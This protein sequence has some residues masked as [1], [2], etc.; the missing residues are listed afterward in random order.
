[1][2]GFYYGNRVVSPAT[3]TLNMNSNSITNI[4]TSGFNLTSAGI[5]DVAGVSGNIWSA[6]QILHSGSGPN[7]IV[8][9]SV[10]TTSTTNILLLRHQT[11]GDMGDGFG[12]N[13]LFQAE[14]TSSGI[15]AFGDI[16]F[17]RSGSSDGQTDFNL[18]T[19]LTSSPNLAFTVTAA[20]IGGFDAAGADTGNSTLFDEYDDP[21]ELKRMAYAQSSLIPIDERLAHCERMV[22]IGIYR[23]VPK[24][25]SGFHV[26]VQPALG[27]LAGGVYQ[28]RAVIIQ[29][30]LDIRGLRQELLDSGVLEA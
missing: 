30:T 5:V 14:D 23:R 28:N 17:I 16:R 15:L 1:M 7:N 10:L 18:L 8:R 6:T 3:A 26:L 12:P 4:G 13:L 9:T 21:T 11:S 25:S 2:G 20:G 19:V 22:D 29:N 27:L 24:A